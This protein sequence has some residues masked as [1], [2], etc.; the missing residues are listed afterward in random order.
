ME[1]RDYNEVPVAYFELEIEEFR[2]DNKG[3]KKRS[4]TYL[5]FEAWDSAAL[6][7]QKYANLND[8]MVVESIARNYNDEFSTQ[9]YFR[10]TN[11][12]ILN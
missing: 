6:A 3:D 4:V 7:I 11:F 12:K 10:V 1:I 8:I 9:T 5:D 2:K